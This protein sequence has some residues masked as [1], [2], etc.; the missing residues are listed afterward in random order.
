MLMCAF[1]Y[2]LAQEANPC[3]NLQHCVCITHKSCLL[4]PAGHT[5]AVSQYKLEAD[6]ENTLLENCLSWLQDGNSGG[7]PWQCP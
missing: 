7:S 5:A 1:S 4:Q 2:M 6:I 3:A